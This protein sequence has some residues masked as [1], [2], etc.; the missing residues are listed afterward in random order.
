MVFT[1]CKWPGHKMVARYNINI[2]IR[3]LYKYVTI[4]LLFTYVITAKI[5][6]IYFLQHLVC[7]L[8]SFMP[9]L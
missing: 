6:K 2:I 5:Y 4:I 8:L 3:S 9:L 7:D 1:A